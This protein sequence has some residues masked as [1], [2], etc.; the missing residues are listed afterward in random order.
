M[1]KQLESK[2]PLTDTEIEQYSRDGF[3]IIKNGCSHDLI[4]A[5]NSHIHTIR[6]A[7]EMPDWVAVKDVED[8][9]KIR[10]FN[11]HLHDGFA[12]QMMKLPI[13]KRAL[14]QLMGDEAVGV[15][16]MYFYKEP[17]SKG[18]AAHQDYFYIKNQPNTMIAG[19]IALEDIDE[20]NGCL[21]VIPGS[22]K[23]GLLSHGKVKNVSEHEP[24]TDET[25]GIDLAEEIPVRMKKGDIL[26]F[27]NLLIHSSKRNRSK[28]RWR[29]SYVCH[30]IRH[31]SEIER[32][33]LKRK[34]PLE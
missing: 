3:Y 5:F 6:S 25:E 17:G 2:N 12:L 8:R 22:Q 16:S 15:Q 10:V 33:D 21:W 18:Q 27:H 9:F 32:E 23:S 7:Q 29:K 13:I 30:Y 34:I 19:Y 26:F 28:N 4:E 1:E 14:A 24:W 31:D 20:E 11:P